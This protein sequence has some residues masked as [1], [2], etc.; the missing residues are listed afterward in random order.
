MAPSPS[1][2]LERTVMPTA[3]LA[4]VAE[5]L[6][7]KRRRDREEAILVVVMVAVVMVVVEGEGVRPP[8]ILI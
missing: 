1:V 4:T 3:K 5:Q 7:A 8:R 6:T 2:S